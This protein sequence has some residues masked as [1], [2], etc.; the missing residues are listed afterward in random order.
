MVA[1]ELSYFSRGTGRRFRNSATVSRELGMCRPGGHARA[2][3]PSLHARPARS[4]LRCSGPSARLRVGVPLLAL[5]LGIRF[6]FVIFCL[7]LRAPGFG[8][9]R[10][11]SC[12]PW[13][14]TSH[15]TQLTITYF[16]I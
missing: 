7:G 8:L 15:N 11:Q 2:R 13:E 10:V 5:A 9:A 12:L 4:S 1:R 6:S 3:R 14:N 16:G